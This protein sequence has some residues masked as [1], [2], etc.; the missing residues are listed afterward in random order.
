MA[1]RDNRPEIEGGG[2]K[3]RYGYDIEGMAGIETEGNMSKIALTREFAISNIVCGLAYIRPSVKSSKL[4][5]TMTPATFAKPN[6]K[7]YYT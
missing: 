3:E 4:I 2:F 7:L 1:E 6:Y 5:L